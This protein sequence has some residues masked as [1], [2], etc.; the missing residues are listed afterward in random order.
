MVHVHPPFLIKTKKIW[1][2]DT[3]S[4]GGTRITHRSGPS[5]FP[6][7]DDMTPDKIC[8]FLLILFYGETVK[9]C[10]TDSDCSHNILDDVCCGYDSTCNVNCAGL[11]CSFNGD[12]A[13]WEYCCDGV[14]Q[15]NHCYLASWLIAVITISVLAVV[16]AVIGVILCYFC[17]Y[18]RRSPGLIV[19][20]PPLIAPITTTGFISG[21]SV[22]QG[23]AYP[24]V[25]PGAPCY[26]QPPPPT[27]YH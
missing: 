27:Y 8:F 25:Q 23:H 16:G 1:T 19:R 18:R 10:F 5:S 24:I 12:C 21:S 3:K 7:N 2:L 26:G 20:T 14:C 6:T 9:A 13:D 4:E 22:V 11:S 17:S 15:E